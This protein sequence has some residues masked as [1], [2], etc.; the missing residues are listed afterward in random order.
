MHRRAAT[1]YHALIVIHIFERLG[2]DI[3]L[4]VPVPDRWRQ[5]WTKRMRLWLHALSV[6][7]TLSVIYIQKWKLLI[8]SRGDTSWTSCISSFEPRI[9]FKCI[10]P[11]TSSQCISHLCTK[12]RCSCVLHLLH[13][14]L[15]LPS[16]NYSRSLRRHISS[17][18]PSAQLS[19][20]EL[21][22]KRYLVQFKVVRR[23]SACLSS[24]A[25][26]IF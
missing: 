8:W 15:Y 5:I 14:D 4:T 21:S 19:V 16:R 1:N 18:G 6:Q 22:R 24:P 12:R 11:P 26:F 9:L 23:C 25:V 17:T 3:F 2:L 7:T 20:A 13:N 10:A